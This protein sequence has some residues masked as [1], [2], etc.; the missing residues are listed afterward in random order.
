[1]N[2]IIPPLRHFTIYGQENAQNMRA[3]CTVVSVLQCSI[4]V[5]N[6]WLNKT[7]K[8]S[9][10]WCGGIINLLFDGFTDNTRGHFTH[11]SHLSSPLRGSEKYY[12]TRKISTRI[13]CKA[14][15]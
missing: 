3:Y 6:Y 1:M 14:I 10:K 5:Y 15:E 7:V 8:M 12:A 9:G 11:C 2:F 4:P 13:T